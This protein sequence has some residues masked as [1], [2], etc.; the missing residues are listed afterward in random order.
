MRL[1]SG[2]G[3]EELSRQVPGILTNV[4]FPRRRFRIPIAFTP[5]TANVRKSPSADSRLLDMSV[6]VS[7]S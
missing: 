2:A 5:G 7:A 4:L 6:F 3:T 1:V